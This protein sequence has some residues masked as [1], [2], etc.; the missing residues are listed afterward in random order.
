MEYTAWSPAWRSYLTRTRSRYAYLRPVDQSQWQ[1]SSGWVAP[2]L[3]S[4]WWAHWVWRQLQFTELIRHL[5]LPASPLTWR[6]RTGDHL[7]TW[8]TTI[9]ADLELR[10]RLWTIMKALSEDFIWACTCPSYHGC[11]RPWRSQL[12]WRCRLNPTELTLIQVQVRL[13]V[14]VSGVCLVLQSVFKVNAVR[15]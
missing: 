3:V 14:N 13:K 15:W 7:K 2:I 12:D 11:L 5:L 9:K 10:P 6:R 1:H 4:W 8:T